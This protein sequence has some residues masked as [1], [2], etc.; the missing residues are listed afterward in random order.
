MMYQ[1][2]PACKDYLWGG[3]RLKEEYGKASDSP[4]LAETWELSCHKDGESRLCGTD[5]T[6][7][8]YIKQHPTACG[9]A[10]ARFATFPVLIKLIDAHQNL[11]IQVHPDDAYAKEHEGQQ[12]KTEMWHIVDATP[13]AGIYYG[14]KQK[15][16]KAELQ[17]A[18]ENG[19]VCD[20]LRWVPVHKGDSFFIEAGTIHAI[21]AGCLI[22]EVQ[23][24]SNVTYRV[25]DYNRT[26]KDGHQ[27][28]LH[29]DKACDVAKLK[30]T[31]QLEPKNGHLA[32]C[33]Y[34][35]VDKLD[36]CG[37]I[38]KICGRDSFHCLLVIEGELSI[39]L[40]A[41]QMQAQ[42]GDT[43]FIEAGS[44]CYTIKG[45]GTALLTYVEESGL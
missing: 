42:K 18:I 9:T 16:T 32:S 24:N 39:T 4:I 44:G 11:S 34:F 25:Y 36:I 22:A 38:E 8:D 27:R 17:Q 1:L 2:E 45:S 7:T 31:Q 26:D 19:T 43:V 14:L 12:G 5:Q 20:L 6:L 10:C 28:E 37:R 3:T 41:K 40:L 23:Q 35:T 15:V 13:D 30:P 33:N 29:I 21:G